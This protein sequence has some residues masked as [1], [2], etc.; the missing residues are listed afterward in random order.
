M[1]AG[2]L[3]GRDHISKLPGLL[4][5]R[6]ALV[7]C[8]VLVTALAAVTVSVFQ[9]RR[10]TS[11][12]GILLP[13]SGDEQLLALAFS[14]RPDEHL[15]A[16][17]TA[18]SLHNGLGPRQIEADVALDGDRASVRVR[19]T[20]KDP[21]A[22]ASL[23][24]AFAREYAAAQVELASRAVRN[25]PAGSSTANLVPN[26]SFE[27]GRGGWLPI[28]APAVAWG[29]VKGQWAAD[30]HASLRISS[31]GP[32][33]GAGT[34]DGT[35]GIPAKAN[36]SYVFSAVV[37]V[38][39]HDQPR[40]AYL[41]IRWISASGRLVNYSPRLYLGGP[42]VSRLRYPDPLRSP[43][44]AAY[45]RVELIAERAAGK[46]FDANLDDVRLARVR[47]SGVRFVSTPR[48][49]G[50]FVAALR[51]APLVEPATVVSKPS[52]PR[53]LAAALVAVLAGSFIAL[54]LAALT[55]RRQH[56]TR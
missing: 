50:S 55:R 2:I 28:G 51:N 26:A 42:R 17:R 9:E 25:V 19:G 40:P 49:S 14:R 7:G 6:R 30:G 37:R 23:T 48:G 33:A 34:P 39:R 46:T 16:E 35:H 54:A 11:T 53:T 3:P 13:S 4:D 43:R 36:A 38:R 5:R 47:V 41:R 20:R 21:H 18:R 27:G 24:T 44:G 22:A 15:V 1:P 31:P 10:Y 32:M 29:V 8:M 56:A 45:A 52:Y 12:A